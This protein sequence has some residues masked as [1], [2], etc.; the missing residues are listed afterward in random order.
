[1][2]DYILIDWLSVKFLSELSQNKTYIK[3]LNIMAK[4]LALLHGIQE[5][6][7]VLLHA[8]KALG[9]RGGIA[10]AHS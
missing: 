5:V 3:W 6:K 10:P 2:K 9:G 7:S 4:W 1:M 8:M